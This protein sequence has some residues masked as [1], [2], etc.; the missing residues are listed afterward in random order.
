MLLMTN[1]NVHRKLSNTS[2]TFISE[3]SL[4]LYVKDAAI[5][6]NYDI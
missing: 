2:Q 4:R 1:D 3:L 5:A 6:H